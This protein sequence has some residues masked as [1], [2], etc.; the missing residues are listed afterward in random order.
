MKPVVFRILAL[1]AVCALSFEA[2]SS[3]PPAL[4]GF[5]F[6]DEDLNYSVN[7]P[8]GLS[9]GEAH[10]HA[11]RAGPN[12][13]F[14]FM[15]DAGI[16]GFDV[17]DIYRGD[18]TP[19]FCSISFDR[20]T[21]H[22]S[23]KVTDKETIDKGRRMAVRST[24]SGGQS[25]VPVPNCVKD[26]LTFLFY[27]REELGQGRVPNPEQILFGGLYQMNLS[28]A[29]AVMVTVGGKQEQSDE[30]ACAVRGPSAT[31]TFDMYFAR[32]AARTPLLVKVPFAMGTF[33]MELI[34]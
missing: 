27:A 7:W 1:T 15:V 28:Y 20:S 14:S 11:K 13:N 32:D 3:S 18:S 4:T 12:W 24:T 2:Q 9:A 8:G 10:L 25:E 16:P 22:G 29:G 23:R 6:T 34:R 30:I 5:P 33:S 26:A 17:R 21:T 19:D 31:V